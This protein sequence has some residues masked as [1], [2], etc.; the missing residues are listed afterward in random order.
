[1]KSRRNFLKTSAPIA[2][3]SFIPKGFALANLP[4]NKAW[5][6]S[7]N[8]GSIRLQ[9]DAKK[10]LEQAHQYG[11]HSI[12][13]LLNE[14]SGF[15]DAQIEDYLN[16]MHQMDLVFDAGGL[17]ID[18]RKD[19]ITFLK[20]FNGLKSN[21][22]KFQKLNIKG[23]VTWIMPTHE[24]R[25]YLDNFKLHTERLGLVATLLDD[26]DMK[27]GLEYVGAKTLM[28]S[29]KYAFIRTISELRALISTINKKNVGY[30]L[31]SFHM[32]CAEDRFE[33]YEFLTRE[34]IISVQINDA[35]LGR[36]PAEQIDLER[37]LPGATGMINLKAFFDFLTA[38]HYDGSVSVEPFN[39]AINSQ[40][41][42]IK[43][44]NVMTAIQKFS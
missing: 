3:M 11:F 39:K 12:S 32:Y 16:Q 9:T 42:A 6:P 4:K 31:D 21:L 19:E 27:L 40:P 13:P 20:G 15:T 22:K 1:M 29:K 17:P 28:I 5:K 41:E 43:L 35:V 37:E 34:D 33:E 38:K 14:L 36:S 2:A 23:F 44:K 7:L 26:Y 10:I 24:K 8:P 25:P 30:L 18:F